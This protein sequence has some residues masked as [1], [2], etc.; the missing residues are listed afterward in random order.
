MAN[1]PIHDPV[2][3]SQDVREILTTDPVHA[4]IMNEFIER[5][6]NNDVFLKALLDRLMSATDGHKHTGLDGDAPKIP[7]SSIVED[8]ALQ[9]E[10]NAHTGNTNNPHNVTWAQVGAESP[11]GAQSKVD[12]HEAKGSPHSDHVKGSIRIS[13]GTVAPSN[14]NVNDVWIDT[15]Q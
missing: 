6:I 3:F 13:V 4:D 15:N 14:P 11:A 10:L 7:A 1:Q 2:D 8:I 5:L 9:S 12:T